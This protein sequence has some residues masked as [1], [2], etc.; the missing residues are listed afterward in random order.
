MRIRRAD[1]ANF[2]PKAVRLETQ[3]EP[4][5]QFKPREKNNVPA[6]NQSGRRD[7]LLFMGGSV[8]LFYSG[9]FN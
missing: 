8:F 5:F 6:Q 4:M 3:R 1:G 7:S 9:L 2:S